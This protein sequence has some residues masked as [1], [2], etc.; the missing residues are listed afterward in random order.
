MTTAT[1]GRDDGNVDGNRVG[2]LSL[3]VC[4]CFHPLSFTKTV[5][6]RDANPLGVGVHHQ[7]IKPF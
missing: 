3:C 6:L 2:S 5:N 1:A 7:P 4:V